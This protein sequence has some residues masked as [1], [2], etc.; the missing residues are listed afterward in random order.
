M[1]EDEKKKLESL[2]IELT[3]GELS[4]EQ[5]RWF[6]E[7]MRQHPEAKKYYLEYCQIHTML[8]W[9]HGVLGELHLPRPP[10][11]S[12]VSSNPFSLWKPLAAVAALVLI[13]VALWSPWGDAFQNE[14]G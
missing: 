5:S 2:L 13:G 4:T 1:T 8:A 6:M 11:E 9:E 14:T 7:I 3:E 10:E 12:E